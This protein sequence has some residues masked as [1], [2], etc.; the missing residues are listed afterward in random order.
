MTKKTKEYTITDEM[1]DQLSCSFVRMGEMHSSTLNIFLSL[2][3]QKV[4]FHLLLPSI[5]LSST[6]KQGSKMS[7]KR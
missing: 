6:C 7:E 4:Y 5:G 3:G 1:H 2:F